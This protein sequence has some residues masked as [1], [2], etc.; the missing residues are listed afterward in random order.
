MLLHPPVMYI[1]R[2]GVI[3]YF[4]EYEVQLI[5][6]TIITIFCTFFAVVLHLK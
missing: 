6:G 2:F 3:L 1:A 4:S 5:T